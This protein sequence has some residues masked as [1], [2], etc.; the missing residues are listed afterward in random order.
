MDPV[1]ETWIGMEG[2]K[3]YEVEEQ[4]TTAQQ[5]W[6]PIRDGCHSWPTESVHRPLTDT[7]R[8]GI[9]LGHDMLVRSVVPPVVP[10]SL[11]CQ[12]LGSF[13]VMVIFPVCSFVLQLKNAFL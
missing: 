13:H 5:D 7:D 3:S 6:Q 1:N 10:L 8:D 2:K 4:A 12:F 9:L 11:G